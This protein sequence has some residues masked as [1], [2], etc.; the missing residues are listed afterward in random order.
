MLEFL[1]LFLDAAALHIAAG[2]AVGFAIGLTGV[3]GGSLMTPLLLAFGYSPPVAIGTDLLYAAITKVGGGLSH[4]RQGNVDWRIVALLAA[5]SIPTS[6]LLHATLLGSFDRSGG[7]L[8]ADMPANLLT[9]SLGI[10]LMVTALI[11][12][13]RQRLRQSAIAE[14]PRILMP[15]IHRHRQMVTFIAGILLGVCVTLSS[16]GAGAFCAAVLLV[17]YSQTAA[18]RIVGTDIAHAVPLTLAAGA[19]YLLAGYVDLVLLGSLL[20]GSLPAIHLGTRLSSRVPDKFLQQVLILLLLSLG[21]Y[22]T[23][24]F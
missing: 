18:V 12:L 21:I 2:A 13:F 9:V 8:Q 17:I 10:M 15:F 14:R 16:V 19:G 3:G 1:S 20:I 23:F 24:V 22:Y 4:H 5:G 7:V 11:L 6:L